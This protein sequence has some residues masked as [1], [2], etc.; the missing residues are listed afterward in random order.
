M[1]W[2]ES[3]RF[4]TRVIRKKLETFLPLEDLLLI[5]KLWP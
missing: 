1:V 4:L 5:V 2:P 3:A